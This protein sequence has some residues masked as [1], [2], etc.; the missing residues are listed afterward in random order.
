MALKI[1]WEGQTFDLSML[2]GKDLRRLERVTSQ[3]WSMISP[4]SSIE[5]FREIVVIFAE[6]DGG[7]ARGRAAGEK[8]DD[9]TKNEIDALWSVDEADLEALQGKA[10]EEEP[11]PTT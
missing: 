5:A 9:M 6:R 3:P 1:E 8:F 4:L 2:K 11:D 7:E 10:S